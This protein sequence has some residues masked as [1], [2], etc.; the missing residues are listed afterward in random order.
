MR[1]VVLLVVCLGLVCCVVDSR[2]VPHALVSEQVG[3]EGILNHLAGY[4]DAINERN[5]DYIT[6]TK[7][8]RSS[9]FE[10]LEIVK[11]QI[12]QSNSTLAEKQHRLRVLKLQLGE[13]QLTVGSQSTHDVL[14]GAANTLVE[15]ALFKKT[16]SRQ[17]DSDRLATKLFDT[18]TTFANSLKQTLSNR[19]AQIQCLD[20]VR[21]AL[22]AARDAS[23]KMILE[24]ALSNNATFER[25]LLAQQR[26]LVD[27][28]WLSSNEIPLL[29]D[30][31]TMRTELESAEDGIASLQA[32]IT[33]LQA[34]QDTKQARLI[35]L[36]SEIAEHKHL[37]N[38]QI[39]TVARLRT[40]AQ[41]L[42]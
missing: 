29:E 10:R 22:T 19:P 41:G 28:S 31:V 2:D 5:T 23:D 13:V 37:T 36:D 11:T 33:A 24:G 39:D 40:L 18:I 34:E 9:L 7:L 32:Q 25:C 8:L 38:M 17:D 1:L 20:T 26:L 35:Q 4:H 15:C 6:Y 27:K 42:V 21:G 30:V 14:S 3:Q 12:V 16:V